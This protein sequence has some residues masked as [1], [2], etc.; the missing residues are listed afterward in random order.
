LEAAIPYAIEVAARPDDVN[1]PIPCKLMV[2]KDKL[3]AEGGLSEKKLFWGGFST[4]G[5]SPFASQTTS[6][7]H[8]QQ[9]FRK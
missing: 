8:G 9:Q 5:H 6:S 4:S 2:A 3:L 7:S 1:K